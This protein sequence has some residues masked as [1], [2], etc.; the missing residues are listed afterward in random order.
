MFHL[1]NIKYNQLKSGFSADKGHVFLYASSNRCNNLIYKS[2]EECQANYHLSL[3]PYDGKHT[4]VVPRWSNEKEHQL[5]IS[6]STFN[7]KLLKLTVESVRLVSFKKAE[8][9]QDAIV[10]RFVETV[11]KLTECGVKLPFNPSRIVYVTN[12]EKELEEIPLNGSTVNLKCKP[13]SY[14]AIKVFG[15]FNM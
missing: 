13:F 10:M 5:I 9:C 7:G 15:D 4:D 6:A 12:D 11:G 8:D 2:I 3:L 1:G 14:T